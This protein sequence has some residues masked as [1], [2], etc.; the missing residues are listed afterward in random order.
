M[1]KALGHSG[2]PHSSG[3]N[4]VPGRGC[5]KVVQYH[6]EIWAWMRKNRWGKEKRKLW[7]ESLPVTIE[8]LDPHVTWKY[9]PG[10][11]AMVPLPYPHT[12]A[13]HLE[14]EIRK[15]PVYGRT[16][17][18]LEQLA[19]VGNKLIP[20]NSSEHDIGRVCDLSRPFTPETFVREWQNTGKEWQVLQ[21]PLWV[22]P[23]E[24]LWILSER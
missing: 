3:W 22:R 7:R 6:N 4:C 23:T 18:D 21:H 1:W 13:F 12:H 2:F 14:A 8:T 20:R 19:I 16:G 17:S 15:E 24:T 5:P 9:K 11:R 10:T